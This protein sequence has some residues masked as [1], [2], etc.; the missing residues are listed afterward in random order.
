MCQKM[1]NT[2][3]GLL[4]CAG[5]LLLLGWPD[6]M[7]SRD[8]IGMY[9]LGYTLQTDLATAEGRNTAWDDVH[10]VA[11]LQGIVNR[12][13]ARLYV[14]FVER[15]GVGIDRYWFD[16]YRRRGQWLYGKETVTY[17]T[18]EELV[19]AY[20]DYV[21]GVVLYDGNVPSTSNVASSVAG[22]D[23]LLPVRYDPSPGS[24]YDRLVTHGPC[25]PVKC[26]L[27]NEDG[28][29]MFTGKGTIP[30]TSRASTG[31]V[32]NDPYIWY[33]ENYMKQGRCNTEYAGYYIDQYWKQNPTAANRNHHTL[34]NHDFFI[35]KRGFF[36]DLSPWG[37]E[38]ATDEPGQPAGTDLATLKEMLLLAYRQ[39]EG[40][41]FCYIGGFPAWAYKYTMHAGGIH[42]DVPTEW[43]FS[44]LIGAYNAFKDADAIGYGALA[45]A[46]FW[47]HFPLEGEYPQ[48]WITH[49]QLEERGLLT[50][51][52]KVDTGGKQ[53][54][55][56]YVGDYDAS[57]WISQMSS[58]TW[59]DPA[60]GQ[61][62]L[63]WSIS[64]VL[65]E[66]APHVLH[67]FRTTA[68]PND[69]FASADNGAGYLNPGMLQEPRPFSALPSGTEAWARHCVPYYKRWGLTVTGFI[70]DGYAPGLDRTGLDAYASFSPNGIVP[71][72]TPSAAWM[73]GGMPVLQADL[74]INDGDP[75]VAA[76][77]IVER[78]KERSGHLPFHWFRNILKRPSWYVEV[79]DEVARLD[80]DIVLLDA[81]SFFE[82]L[83]IWLKEQQPFAGGEGTEESPFLVATPEQFD[84]IRDYRDCCFR[85]ESDLDFSGY[86]RGDGQSWW[87]LGEWGGGNGA[88]ERFSGVFDGNGHVIRNLCVERK[89]HDLSI[90][91]VTEGAV[92]RNLGVEHCT[93]IGEGRLGI[94]TGAAFST[95]LERITVADCRCENRLSD[96][97]S[98]AGGL[99]GPLYASG[100]E[101][102]SVQGGYVYA[103]DCVGG[104]SSSM[105]AASSISNCYSTARLEGTSHVGGIAGKGG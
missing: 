40:E 20:A 39:N 94:V 38:P 98:H 11:A 59:D 7:H 103:K 58:A 24:L 88:P 34:S 32:K 25:L 19:E 4:F 64:P 53:F 3:K 27:V 75:K 42:D 67:Y 44:R 33:I 43:E 55:I 1:R 48:P 87:P 95:R 85:L 22:S 71:Q 63:M 49:E 66:R 102:C 23:D 73:Y 99:T 60:R 46:S 50:P 56:F 90:F 47:Q 28:S 96:H 86:V 76:S 45:N 35:S 54:V 14:Y 37:D 93:I 84:H 9:D 101:C 80:K 100:V 6:R 5:A 10:L 29:P 82:L 17:G 36:F 72:K 104:I 65:E 105:D 74:D 83:R 78:V 69:Y 30:S 15:D 77:R 18:I 31:S 52:G 21:E 81:P 26:R 91:G 57:S 8:V 89:A 68:T 97:G 16:K 2:M 13:A 92:I 79:M 51:D 12:D 62:P 70:V 41:R 61:L